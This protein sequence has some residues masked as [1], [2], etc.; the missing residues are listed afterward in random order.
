MKIFRAMLS[1]VAMTTL[2][3]SLL[4]A[5]PGTA[6]ANVPGQA[7]QDKEVSIPFMPVQVPVPHENEAAGKA[8]SRYVEVK[9]GQTLSGIASSRKI[10]WQSLYCVNKKEIGANPDFIKPGEKL[11]IPRVKISCKIENGTQ[12]PAGSVQSVSSQ[13]TYQSQQPAYVNPGSYGSFQACVISRESGGN[14]DIW[15]ATGHWGLY[16]FSYSTWVAYGGN[17]ADFGTASVA[18]QNQVFANAMATPGGA[19]NWAPYDGC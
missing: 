10:G 11:F 2:S 17:P 8:V 14:P 16:Q 3:G 19:N 9:S 18:E 13:D 1:A 7:S 15:N 5:V 12:N 6:S 4:V